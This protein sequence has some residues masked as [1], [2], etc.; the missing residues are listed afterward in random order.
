MLSS[1]DTLHFSGETKLHLGMSIP[2]TAVG[3]YKVPL[4]KH[5]HL[6]AHLPAITEQTRAVTPQV[7]EQVKTV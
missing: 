5:Q 4:A 7:P 6:P 1:K 2:L 3:I